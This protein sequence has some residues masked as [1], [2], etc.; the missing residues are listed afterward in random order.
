MTLRSLKSVLVFTMLTFAVTTTKA[1]G[2][3]YQYGFENL[4]GNLCTT[5]SPWT[6]TPDILATGLSSSSWATSYTGGFISYAGSCGGTSCQALS[7]SHNDYPATTTYTLTFTVNAGYTLSI[8]DL[9]FWDKESGTGPKTAD[10]TINGT[11]AISAL[12]LSGT[13]GGNTGTLTPATSFNNLTGTVTLVMTLSGATS[14]GGTFRLDDFVIDGTVSSGTS[15]VNVYNVTGGGSFCPGDPGVVV[16]LTGSDTG[17]SYQLINSVAGRV[18][19]P[20]QGTGSAISFGTQPAAGTYTVF[21]SSNSNSDTATMA[22]NAIL[23]INPA[24]VINLGSAITQC[25]GTAVLDAGNPGSTFLWSDN[26]IVQFDTVSVTNVYSVTVTGSNSCSASASVSVTINPPPPLTVSA[27]PTS[28]CSGQASVIT[29]SGAS[30]YVWSNG[31]TTSSIT[32]NP[33]SNSTYTV[34][35]TQNLCTATGSASVTIQSVLTGSFST[36]ICQGQSYRGH[37]TSGTYYDTLTSAGGC[38]SIVTLTLQVMQG[39]SS[40]MSQTICSGQSFMGHS[41]AGSFVDTLSSVNGCDSLVTIQLTVAPP[42]TGST[43][44]TICSGQNFNGH[45]S[46]GTY[47]DTVQAA[48]GCDSIVTLNLTVLPPITLALSHSICKYDTFMGHTTSGTYIDTL[49]AANGCDSLVYLQLTV[50]PLPHVTLYLTFDT[51]CSNAS[52]ITMTGGSP[53][54]GYYSGQGISNSQFVPSIAPLGVDTIYYN[55]TDSNGCFKYRYEFAYTEICSDTTVGI[56]E[57]SNA[58]F[59]IYPNPAQDYVNI[60][61]NNSNGTFSISV[62]DLVGRLVLSQPETTSIGKRTL[63]IHLLPSGLY[64]LNIT[65][66]HGKITGYKIVKE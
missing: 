25:G 40:T 49:Q 13:G 33:V 24:P 43:S 45:S 27:S 16:G 59:M 2:I 56:N 5:A 47:Y 54:G 3:I 1:A 61:S 48:G 17:V 35:A 32:V 30:S 53:P 14:N 21:A 22:G 18:G 55:Y 23:T 20:V 64:L 31:L 12:T 42:L 28:V 4:C 37:T 29:A 41:A 65:D 10:I 50:N 6:G 62:Y 39:G 26:N 66:E 15:T 19:T 11:T 36:S 57:I 52:A 38:D 34:T 7:I 60:E 58:N 63:D 51:V 44:Q 9:L 46:T 8:T